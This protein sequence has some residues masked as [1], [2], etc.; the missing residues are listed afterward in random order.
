MLQTVR[1]SQE[2]HTPLSPFFRGSFTFGGTPSRQGHPT[3]DRDRPAQR[4]Q[5][6]FFLDDQFRHPACGRGKGPLVE[7]LGPLIVQAKPKGPT[8]NSRGSSQ[9]F[10]RQFAASQTNPNKALGRRAE[11]LRPG[12]WHRPR[13]AVG[14]LV[15]EAPEDARHHTRISPWRSEPPNN[16]SFAKRTWACL[17]LPGPQNAGFPFGFPLSPT[18]RGTFKTPHTQLLKVGEGVCFLINWARRS[19]GR[20]D[21]TAAQSLESLAG[22]VWVGSSAVE[23]IW[24]GRGGPS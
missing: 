16:L 24:L 15:T 2:K 9:A 17:F 20:N 10:G 22:L 21:V 11:R 3:S 7:G 1:E 8:P 12:P 5:L 18:K 4:Y 14:A 13:L 6:R 23:L 19:K